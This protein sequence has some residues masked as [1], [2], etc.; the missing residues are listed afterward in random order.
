MNLI[1][2][3]NKIENE[4]LK[5]LERCEIKLKMKHLKYLKQNGKWNNFSHI[6]TPLPFINCVRKFSPIERV[7]IEINLKFNHCAMKID[8][9]G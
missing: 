1:G 3:W 9:V 6:S 7:K 2:K 8:Y 5:I 4:T